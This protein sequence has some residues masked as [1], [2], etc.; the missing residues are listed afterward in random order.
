[1]EIEREGIGVKIGIA[2]DMVPGGSQR[3]VSSITFTKN[4]QRVAFF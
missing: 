2:F 4:G 3:Y 1:M